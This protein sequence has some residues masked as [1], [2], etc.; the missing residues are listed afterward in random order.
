MPADLQHLAVWAALALGVGVL[1]AAG[2]SRGSAP[3]AEDGAAGEVT[4]PHGGPPA[5]GSAAVTPPPAPEPSPPM[6]PD[7][8]TESTRRLRAGLVAELRRDGN[9]T[10][11]RVLAVLGAVPRHAF[12]PWLL[13]LI[14]I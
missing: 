7:L 2:C 9:V 11:E 5:T 1:I 12:A 4:T 8:D 10:D 13:S 6:A 3:P 14:H